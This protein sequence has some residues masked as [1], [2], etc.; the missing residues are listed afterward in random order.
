MTAENVARLFDAT[1]RIEIGDDNYNEVVRLN[2]TAEYTGCCA[3][4]DF[5]DANMVML[6]VFQMIG[7]DDASDEGNSLW[8][9]S[10]NAWRAM[11]R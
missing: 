11:T 9:R 6:K 3:S 10:W 2:R 7:A 8:N 4:H 1:L 5:C